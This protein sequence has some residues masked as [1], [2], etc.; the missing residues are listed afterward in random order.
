[1]IPFLREHSGLFGLFYILGDSAYPNNDLMLSVFKGNQLPLHAVAFNK[2][3]CPLQTSVEW[4]YEKIVKYWAFLDF[5]KQMKIGKSSI[6][7]MWHTAVFFTNVLTCTKGGNQISSFFGLPP[8]SVEEY[9]QR[10]MI[11]F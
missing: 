7:A 11:N 9:I 6:I 5:K 8:P 4:G 1:L 2:I 10:A 3:V